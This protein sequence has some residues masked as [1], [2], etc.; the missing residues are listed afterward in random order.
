LIATIGVNPYFIAFNAHCWFAFAIMTFA[1]NLSWWAFGVCVLLAGVKEFW[2]D[3]HYE[4]PKQTFMDNFTDF[5]GYLTGL[6]IGALW[7]GMF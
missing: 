4:T 5:L 3:A 1:H 6:L 7:A 2:F